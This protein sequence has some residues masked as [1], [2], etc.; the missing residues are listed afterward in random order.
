MKT[1]TKWVRKYML[2]LNDINHISVIIFGHP[3]IPIDDLLHPVDGVKGKG[4]DPS[5]G[6][7]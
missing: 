1:L 3:P 6:V 4:Q 7:L 2:W 5:H